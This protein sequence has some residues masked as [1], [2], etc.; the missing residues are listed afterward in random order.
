[1][2]KEI[3]LSKDDHVLDVACGRGASA[4][5]LSQIF[6]CQVTGIDTS[7]EAIEQARKEAHRY[8]LEHLATFALGDVTPLPFP[9]AT[10]TATF[11]ECATS[12]FSDR[13]SAFGEMSRVL[14]PGGRLALS[15]VTFR[16]ATLP[17]PVDSPL[18]RALCIPLGMG[19]ERYVQFMEEAGLVIQCQT[20]YSGAI[21][22]L[23]DK[24]EWLLGVG[25][26][27]ASVGQWDGELLRRVEAALRCARQLL[28]G[29]E[30]GYWAF[31]ARKRLPPQ[32]VPS[33]R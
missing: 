15:D 3:R 16:P 12:L 9:A 7:T 23:L 13:R 21:A 31:I 14:Q 4:L 22:Q 1:L 24:V 32:G 11:C 18:A 33:E 2:A 10:F 25:Q 29:G 28:H 30:L 8:R 5:M 20:D 17:E 6:K 27:A 26:L 19:P